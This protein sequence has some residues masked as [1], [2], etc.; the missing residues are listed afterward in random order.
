MIQILTIQK[1]QES[2]LEETT[3]PT[4]LKSIGVVII[5]SSIVSLFNYLML[6]ILIKN[7]QYQRANGVFHPLLLR[8]GPLDSDT[9]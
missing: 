9:K 4:L 8:P 5:L 3:I 6:Q 7:S 2:T 1:Q